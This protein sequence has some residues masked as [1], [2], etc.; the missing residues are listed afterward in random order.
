V[1]SSD[2]LL[3]YILKG[4]SHQA[5]EAAMVREIYQWRTLSLPVHLGSFPLRKAFRK[6]QT[7]IGE[8]IL[9]EDDRVFV[10]IPEKPWVYIIIWKLLAVPSPS[11][12][13]AY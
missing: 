6:F 9:S 8:L 1:S 4:T 11:H 13:A 5:I 3:V 2:A 10:A 7:E 12:Q